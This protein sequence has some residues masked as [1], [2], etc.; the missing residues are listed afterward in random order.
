MNVK[1]TVITSIPRADASTE[2]RQ[3]K[4]ARPAV[5]GDAVSGATVTREF[6]LER[7]NFRPE[8]VMTAL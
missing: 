4:S 5:D 8:R 7:R 3:V 6:L 1:G 2:E